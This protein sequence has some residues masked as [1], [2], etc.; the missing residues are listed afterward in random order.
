MISNA[1]QARDLA[2]KFNFDHC[3]SIVC[4]IEEAAGVGEYKVEV[5]KEIFPENKRKYIEK[6]GFKVM[7]Y[8]ADKYTI[9]W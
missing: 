2:Y 8:G 1:V 7:Y 9:E 4:L 6:L 5:P 3:K